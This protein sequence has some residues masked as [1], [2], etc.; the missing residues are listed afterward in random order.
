[1][2]L[3]LL[4]AEAFF[5]LKKNNYQLFCFHH[6]VNLAVVEVILYSRLWLTK[7]IIFDSD[8]LVSGLTLVGSALPHLV[9]TPLRKGL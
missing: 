1:M 8:R 7:N 3:P 4:F 5:M 2:C 9:S 6:W